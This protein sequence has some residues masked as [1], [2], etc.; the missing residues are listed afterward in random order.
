MLRAFFFLLQKLEAL[1]RGLF[2]WKVALLISADSQQGKPADTASVKQFPSASL[3]RRQ[4]EL[5]SRRVNGDLGSD[6]LLS[7]FLGARSKVFVLAK[8]PSN[9]RTL[10]VEMKQFLIRLM[11]RPEPQLLWYAANR[12]CSHVNTCGGEARSP[13]WVWRRRRCGA[14]QEQ[15]RIRLDRNR[16][17]L[18]SSC[19]LQKWGLP[20]E[21]VHASSK[22]HASRRAGYSPRLPH[23]GLSSSYIHFG[24]SFSI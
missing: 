15:I 14:K 11:R 7:T 12:F 21:A 23:K 1:V 4:H 6:S 22:H 20:S 18:S 3:S 9:L 10:N 24:T 8:C 19:L 13:C 2:F 16:S 17:S 5:F